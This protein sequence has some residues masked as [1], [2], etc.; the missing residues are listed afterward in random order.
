M[1]PNGHPTTSGTSDPSTDVDLSRYLHGPDESTERPYVG[2]SG[3]SSGKVLAV[4]PN[5]TEQK[6]KLTHCDSGETCLTE[7]L[8]LDHD[9]HTSSD[10]KS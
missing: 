2:S 7:G 9:P 6:S 8:L 3:P 4:E 1:D 5:G 10:N